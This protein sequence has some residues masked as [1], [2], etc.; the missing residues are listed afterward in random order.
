MPVRLYH[1]LVTVIV[2]SRSLL[3]LIRRKVRP[4]DAAVLISPQYFLHTRLFANNFVTMRSLL[5]WHCGQSAMSNPY[6][7][8]AADI[9]GLGQANGYRQL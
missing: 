1:V 2:S 6:R 4:C 7:I 5:C 9:K 3:V 8:S